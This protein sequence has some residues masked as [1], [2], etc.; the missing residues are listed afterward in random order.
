MGCAFALLV[1]V[2]LGLAWAHHKQAI[3]KAVQ[4]QPA[5]RFDA[6]FTMP[7]Q[8]GEWKRLPTEVPPPKGGDSGRPIAGLALS[9]RGY[10]SVAGVGLSLSWV[11]LLEGCYAL[12][13]W[14]LL[15]RRSGGGSGT[16]GSL[17]YVEVHMQNNMG[18]HGIL[19]FSLVDES[20]AG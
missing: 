18:M 2:S 9:F 11:S 15:E 20:T 8:I 12:S 14:H 19:W 5:L 13:G 3:A 10:A 16:N 6:S 7:D 17:P 4:L 1:L